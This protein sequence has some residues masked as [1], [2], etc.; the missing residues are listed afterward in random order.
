LTLRVQTLGGEVVAIE[1]HIDQ[2]DF[3]R[4]A[5]QFLQA[6]GDPGA[7]TEDA[8]QCGLAV[9]VR[10]DQIGQLPA[11]GLGIGQGFRQE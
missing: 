4:Q 11:L 10:T 6:L 5:E 3:L 7:A 2:S 8:D 1:R 9:Q